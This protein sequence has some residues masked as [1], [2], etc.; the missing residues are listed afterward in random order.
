MSN[1]RTIQRIGKKLRD[2]TSDIVQAGLPDPVR[3]L[4]RQL[5]APDAADSDPSQNRQVSSQR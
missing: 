2:Q 5:S 3:A 1:N 4:L